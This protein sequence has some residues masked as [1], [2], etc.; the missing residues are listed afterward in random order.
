[1][2]KTF[3]ASVALAASL[4]AG[5]VD[6]VSIIVNGKVITMY[7]IVKLSDGAKI[8]R[9]QA[10][11][12]LIEKRIEES[13]FGKQNISVDDFDVDRKIEQIAAS[14]GLTLPKFREALAARYINFSDYRS[15]IKN[16]IA[17]ERLFQKIT[18]QKHTPIDEKDL[19]LYF[20]NNKQEFAAA[21]KIEALEYSSKDK[22]ALEVLA[23]SPMSS[24]KGVSKTEIT[25]EVKTLEPSLQYLFKHAKE[26][27][28]T[29]VMPVKDRF[30]AYYIKDKKNF[31]TPDF[32]SAKNEVFE[33]LSSK[34]E[35]EAIKDHFE[36]L[37][38]SA[39]VKVVR[40]PN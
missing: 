31:E 4:Y 39:K 12:A 20:E 18:Y 2:K 8:T 10:I 21:T 16:R 30:V 24:D 5:V 37:K 34:R 19:K 13:E 9:Q 27:S 25:V 7:E 14:N 26:G 15:D 22:T 28:F 38:A 35:E 40:V 32:E 23:A 1:M 11:E 6:G 33:K 3:F 17:K 29:Q 36:K